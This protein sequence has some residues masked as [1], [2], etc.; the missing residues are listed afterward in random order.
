MNE[1]G[2][3]IDSLVRDF[4]SFQKI[5]T[6]IGDETR[7]Y[8][9]LVIMQMGECDGVRVADIVDKTNLSRPAVSRHVQV[10]KDAGLLKMRKQGTKTFYY[11]APELKEFD[12]FI[13]VLQRARDLTAQI[14]ARCEE[15]K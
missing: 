6:A 11:Y 8:L 7:Q 10:L 4:K 5:L 13:N 1:I 15:E 14:P 9:I 12:R 3:E 2:K